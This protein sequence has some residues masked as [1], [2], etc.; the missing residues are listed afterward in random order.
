MEEYPYTL[1]ASCP[2]NRQTELKLEG[3]EQKQLSPV[4][5]AGAHENIKPGKSFSII[6]SNPYV[7]NAM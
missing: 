5:D 7:G 3:I 1:R 6:I 2:E 4:E